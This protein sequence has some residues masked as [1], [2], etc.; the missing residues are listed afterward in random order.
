MDGSLIQIAPDGTRR[1][2]LSG[3]GLESATALT[4]GPDGAVYV[5]SFGDRPG[6]GQVLRIDP[7]AKVPESNSALGVLAFGALGVGSYLTRKRRQ[8]LVSCG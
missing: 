1:T 4:I 6:V 5:S 2:L 8:K 3:N 7:K